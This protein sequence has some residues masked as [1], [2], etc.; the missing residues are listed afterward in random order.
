MLIRILT[1]VNHEPKPLTPTFPESSTVLV[2]VP[3]IRNEAA[4]AIFYHCGKL[5]TGNSYMIRTTR[6]AYVDKPR[7]DRR[8][9]LYF[10]NSSPSFLFKRNISI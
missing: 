7:Y 2:R 8:V 1:Y 4:S 9:K 6:R 3:K 5:F 10:M